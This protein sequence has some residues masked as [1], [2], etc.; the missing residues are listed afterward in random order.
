MRRPKKAHATWTRALQGRRVSFQRARRKS[1]KGKKV[2]IIGGGASAVEALEFVAASEAAHTTI[3]ARS[4]KWI[5]LRNPV[6]DILL[7]LNILGSE[8]ILSWIPENILRLFFYRDLADLSPPRNSGNG[9]FTETPMVNSDVL[10]LVRSGKA[11]W[12]RGD[13]LEYSASGD[14]ILFNH[15]SQGVPKSGPGA[16]KL[17]EADIVIMATGYKRPTLKFL[18]QSCF[19]D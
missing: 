2:V 12:L 11:S 4:E 13:I 5:I 15:R 14:G 1:A 3:L 16:E 10:D 7:S 18:S 8:T 17:I 9:I 19:E 6:V